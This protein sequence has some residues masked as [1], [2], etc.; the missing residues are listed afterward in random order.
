M[1][2]AGVWS[3]LVR[4]CYAARRS[5][6]TVQ[7]TP[8]SLRTVR[9]P[10]CSEVARM[11]LGGCRKMWNSRR[12]ARRIVLPR[13]I[14]IRVHH[15]RLGKLITSIS[16]AWSDAALDPLLQARLAEQ[17][18]GLLLI[19]GRELDAECARCA[20]LQQLDLDRADATTD[21]QHRAALDALP[22]DEVEDA[23]RS[24]VKAFAPVAFR[25][26]PSRSLAEDPPISLRRAAVAHDPT[27]A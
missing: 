25:L 2:R 27:M 9:S 14:A 18:R 6:A 15:V 22:L 24:R 17:G 7:S 5:A 11:L 20:C 3:P 19:G 12:V 1:L 21:L 4:A 13:S 16:R 23:P 8:D 10:C 26:R